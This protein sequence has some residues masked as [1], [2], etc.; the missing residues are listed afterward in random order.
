MAWILFLPEYSHD[1]KKLSNSPDFREVADV[2]GVIECDADKVGKD[3]QQVDDV[4]QRLDEL[5]FDG[6]GDET[7]LEKNQVYN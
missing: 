3:G 4:H 6:R 2:G 1:S 5:G 7:D